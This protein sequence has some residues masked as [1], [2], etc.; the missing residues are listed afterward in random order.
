MYDSEEIWAPG[1]GL[2]PPPHT[3]TGAIYM[4]INL[5]VQNIYDSENQIDPK[6]IYIY[7]T[8]IGKQVHWCISQISNERLQDQW[9]SGFECIIEFHS[10]CVVSIFDK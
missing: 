5:N 4:C 8:I 7:M 3:H 9:S 2:T 10:P 6:A 1:A